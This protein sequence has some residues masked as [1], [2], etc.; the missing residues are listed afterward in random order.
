MIVGLDVGY[1]VTKAV[2][3]DGQVVVFRSIVGIG[4]PDV[5]G[6]SK[7]RFRTILLNGD[8]YTVG[9]DAEK[10]RLPLINTRKRNSIESIAYKVLALA[11]IQRGS[12]S[13]NIVTGLPIDFYSADKQKTQK[14]FG[15]LFP[16]CNITIIPQPAGTF[17]D[18]ILDS[19]GKTTGVDYADKKIGIVD[20]G[21]FT[22]DMLLMD[23]TSPVRE[24]SS[25]V[26]IGI[27]ALVKNIIKEC[28]H[29]RR[30][31]TQTEVEKAL[32]TGYITKYGEQVNIKDVIDKN[33]S[34]IAKNIWAYVNSIWGSEGDIDIFVATGGGALIFKDA[35]VESNIIYPQNPFI[36][37]A[38][39][40]FK[41]GR[42]MYG[43]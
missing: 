1:G 40:F 7:D 27:D 39:G 13:L 38:Y 12:D 9:E 6:I 32:K 22:T 11:A 25:T 28:S 26:T 36:S 33:K 2:R 34:L 18:L 19:N 5:L 24:M 4:T 41:L 16:E 35:F 14:V 21:T 10:F 29:I 42:Q 30:N 15:E 3:S 8:M 43:S 17:F 23:G 31:L 20:I 37:N